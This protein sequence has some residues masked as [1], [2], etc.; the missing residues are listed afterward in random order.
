MKH[1]TGF[2][3]LFAVL[4]VS[5]PVLAED[6]KA[7]RPPM[8]AQDLVTM[9]R[10]GG[11]TVTPDGHYA[12][13]P[14]TVTDPESYKRTTQLYLRDLQDEDGEPIL[15]DLKGSAS[16]A[17]FGADSWLYFLSDRKPEGAEEGTEGT[18]Q[19][20]RAALEGNGNLSGPMQVTNLPAAV[21]GFQLSPDGKRILIYGQTARSCASYGCDDGPTHLPGPG[22]G[23]LY[24]SDVGFIRHWDSW[25][26]PGVY[27]RVFAFDLVEGKASG[28][29]IALDG[30]AE[31]GVLTGDTPTQPFGGGEDI[32]WAANSSGVFFTARQADAGEPR[33]T[34]L[35]IW[36]SDLSGAA[37][38][39]LTLA[40]KATDALP[41][42]S[43]DGKWLAFVAMERPTYEADRQVIQLRDLETGEQR[44]LTANFDRS[45][46]S[47]T[48]TPDSRWIIATA[49]DVLDTP[50][51]RIDPRNGAVERLDLMAGNEAHI[52]NVTPL[53]GKQMLFARD[54]IGGPAELYLS[55]NWQQA[56]PLTEVGAKV[57]G[58][59]ASI[60][61]RRFSFTGAD[62]DTVWGQITKL[63]DQKGPIPTILYVHGG[64]QGSFNDSWS[65][66]WNPRVVASQG[67]AVVS[68]DFHG[69]TGYGQAFT[70]AIT[71]D[72]G[73]KPLEDLQLGLD[74]ALKLDP[75]I[76]GSRACAMGAS[77]G[78]YMM[79]WIAGKWPER[80]NCLVQHD[81]V[82][83]QRAM[84]YE[85]E[86]LWFIEW[87]HGGKAYFEAPE[88]FEKWNPVNF[89]DNWQTPMLVITGEKDFR[90]P[91]T[92]GIASFTALQRKG[93]PGELLVFPDENHW[94][95]KPKNSLQW[96]QTVFAWLDR[97][98][99]KDAEAA[100]E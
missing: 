35:D 94:V 91:Y 2:A 100:A 83:D 60:V 57:L 56:R 76:D 52:G 49:Q 21:E 41:A 84:Y 36:W 42:P 3:S 10:L 32:A 90:I 75:Q 68:V 85:T 66:R 89:V 30:P 28:T 13:Y 82:F 50:A 34:N 55:R 45:F 78:G 27:S 51:F 12:V 93:I 15:L 26:T 81:G 63:E 16:S 79:N 38:T 95:L 98:L 69:S 99:G 47:L 19:V 54:S 73:G 20:W 25:E 46:G 59:R 8:S 9:P 88:E 33:S 64:P 11:A 6:H 18:T 17:A 87:E 77:Y 31:A 92:Q 43:P 62:G 48:W 5:S 39:N 61:T 23:R 71:K 4:A 67:Y 14:V 70:D 22:T 72:W 97:W 44:A 29:G 96:H 37:P 65:S 74:A 80:F 86:E 1:I 24:Q 58:Q 40:N 7:P 53:P